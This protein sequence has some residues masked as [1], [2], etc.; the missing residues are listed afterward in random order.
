MIKK[1][2]LG[3]SLLDLLSKPTERSFFS[4]GIDECNKGEC[5]GPLFIVCCMK[6]SKDMIDYCGDSKNHTMEDLKIIRDLLE[7]KK[8]CC[9]VFEIESKILDLHNINDLI[10]TVQ[11]K[12]LKKYSFEKVYIDSHLNDASVLTNIHKAHTKTDISCKNQM[13]K[14]ETLTGIASI[15]AYYLKEKYYA[16]YSL[17]ANL[18]INGN[19]ADPNTRKFIFDNYPN[20]PELRKKWSLKSLFK[21]KHK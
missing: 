18:S 6:L 11:K 14:M 15:I 19:L 1:A 8:I 10:T 16:N 7:S 9:D 17:K 3:S 21:G 20:V 5:L 12:I 4:A 13:D 2:E